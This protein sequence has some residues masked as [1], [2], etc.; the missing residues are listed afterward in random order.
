MFVF[1]FPFK[2]NPKK[3]KRAVR[4]KIFESYNKVPKE[5]SAEFV[6]ILYKTMPCS[7]KDQM[8]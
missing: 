3:S 7:T 6:V 2:T 5:I 1:V 4:K 8:S